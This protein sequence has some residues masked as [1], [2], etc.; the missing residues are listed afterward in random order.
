MQIDLRLLRQAQALAEYG[1]FSRAAESLNIAQ[2]SLSRGIK[3]L[4]ARVGLPL[5]ERRRS[6]HRPTDFGRVFLDHAAELLAG[7]GDL[8]REVAR[9][10]GLVTGEI[11]V[12]FGAYAAEV[13]APICAPA[14]VAAHPSLRLRVRMEEP[15]ALARC[16]RSRAIDLAVGEA[17]VL[18]EDESVEVVCTLEPVA[19]YV[20][21]RSGHPLTRRSS[22]EL[23]ELLAYPFAQ[24]VMLPTRV[25]RPILAARQDTRLPVFPAIECPS[26]HLA[27]RIVAS[28]DAFTF[29]SLGMLR[30]QLEHGELVPLHQASWMRTD[31]VVGRL[32]QRVLSPPMAAMV[33]ALQRAHT[34]IL[35]EEAALRA[36]WFSGP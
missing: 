11:G 32:R 19:G 30:P 36:R 3:E 18:A 8:E 1:N 23:S 35:T 13:L 34:A 2:P 21:V 14:F 17:S 24:V 7:L 4:E 26:V 16:L 27:A 12:G 20:V 9:A 29:A 28:T 5:F 6:G 25:L 10:K 33:E 31:W 15:A 22:F